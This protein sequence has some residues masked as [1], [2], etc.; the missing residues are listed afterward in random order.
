MNVADSD[1]LCHSTYAMR[2]WII[3]FGIPILFF[4]TVRC[5]MGVKANSGAAAPTV[6][7]VST[8]NNADGSVTVT[9]SGTGFV[10]GST[11]TVSGTV[12]ANVHVLS[13]T[14]LTCVLPNGN[15]QLVNIVITTPSGGSSGGGSSGGGSAYHTLFAMKIV[16]TSG[17]DGDFIGISGADLLCANAAASGSKTST[18]T[19]TWRAVMSTNTVNVRDRITFVSGASIRNTRGETL[20][21]SASSLWNGTLLTPVRYNEDGGVDTGTY[22]WTGS[23]SSG[24]K[25]NNSTCNNWT[26]SNSA[27]T[28]DVG[29]TAQS[30]G[31]WLGG[32]T[33]DCDLFDIYSIYCIN[34]NN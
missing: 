29:S 5:G 23:T 20:V 4:I 7:G 32:I 27:F 34:S 16:L 2:N 30:G 6:S 3:L 26:Q 28:G 8:I 18:L 1:L 11:V 33:V 21:S 12:C 31:T 25:V 24:N 19:G 22:A 13:S 17:H 14:Q 9:I 15:I 10:A